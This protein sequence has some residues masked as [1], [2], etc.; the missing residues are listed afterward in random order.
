MLARSSSCRVVRLRSECNA[1]DIRNKRA[2]YH[3]HLHIAA[4]QKPPL[5]LVFPPSSTSLHADCRSSPSIFIT[6][7]EY[8]LSDTYALRTYLATM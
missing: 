3:N 2:D 4:N 6:S 8:N 5:A 7:Q 1:E